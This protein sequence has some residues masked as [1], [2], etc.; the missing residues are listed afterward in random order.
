MQYIIIGNGV[1]AVAAVEGVREKDPRGAI[2]IISEEPYPTY[3]RPLISYYLAGKIDRDRLWY[4]PESFYKDQGVELSLGVQ[5][6]GLDPKFKSV[7]CSDGSSYSYDKLLLAV[8]GRPI[9]LDLPG[10]EGEDVYRFTTLADAEALLKVVDKAKKA[11]VVGAGLIALKSAEALLMRKLD[12]TLVVRSRIMRSYFDEEA[13]GLLLQHLESK[14]LKFLKGA[15]PKEIKRDKKGRVSKVET[16]QGD[17]SADLVIMAAGVSP[18]T[19][20]AKAA[21]LAVNR[22]VLVDEFLATSD[23]DIYAAGDCTE[24]VDMVTGEREVLPIWPKAYNQG[25]YAGRNMTG[26]KTAHP[27]GLPM[28]SISYYG[29]PTISVGLVN[30]PDD[31]G[32]EVERVI[33]KEEGRYRKLVIKD[34]R[35]VGF[36]LVGDIEKSGLFTSFVKFGFPVGEDIREKLKQGDPSVLLWPE[37]FFDETWN[38][39]PTAQPIA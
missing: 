21:G 15:T 16:S 7:V 25:L 24:A 35:L 34:G 18:E 3:G 31:Q 30:P 8:G 4:R 2:R 1:A 14:G 39:R 38:P 33:E 27:G 13:G 9:E 37:E 17:L 6:T 5:V 10:A 19:T 28:N 22:G 20:L 11:V 32:F 23:P 12:V 36:V 29:L 26:A